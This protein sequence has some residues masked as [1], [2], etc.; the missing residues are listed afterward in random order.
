MRS[1]AG[2]S[3]GIFGS[4]DLRKASACILLSAPP[5]KQVSLSGGA[6]LIATLETFSYLSSR[7]K[8]SPA[9]SQNGH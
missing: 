6:S 2:V 5:G 9:R 7:A 8:S 1:E 3:K 4:A